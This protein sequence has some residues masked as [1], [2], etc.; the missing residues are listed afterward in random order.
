MRYLRVATDTSVDGTVIATHASIDF[1]GAMNPVLLGAMSLAVP[2]AIWSALRR[3]IRLAIWALIWIGANYLPYVALA[4]VS[5]RITYIYYFLP[6]VPA[7]SA[8]I[9]LLILRS[10]LPRAVQ[11]GYVV[12]YL[13]GFGA[14]FPFRQIP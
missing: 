7:L 12:V 1:R 10:G 14:Y 5:N 2:F 11:L 4:L 8:I 13:V 9:A 3:R 6:V